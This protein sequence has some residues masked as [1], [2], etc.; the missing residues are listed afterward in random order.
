VAGEVLSELK[1]RP[2]NWQFVRRGPSIGE[3]FAATSLDFEN[4]E[5]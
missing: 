5:H 4:L 1:A 3:I 2:A